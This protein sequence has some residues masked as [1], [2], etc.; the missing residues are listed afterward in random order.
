MRFGQWIREV[1]RLGAA[2]GYEDMA[3]APMDPDPEYVERFNAGETPD[4]VIESDFAS[5]IAEYGKPE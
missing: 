4:Q 5:H 1:N 2:Y 3:G